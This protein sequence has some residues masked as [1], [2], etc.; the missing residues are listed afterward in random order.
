MKLNNK[1]NQGFTLLELILTIILVSLIFLTA[2]RIMNQLMHVR[3]SP[4]MAYGNQTVR[5]LIIDTIQND[6][7]LH[8]LTFSTPANP[9]PP[10]QNGGNAQQCA[11]LAAPCVIFNFQSFGR[12]ARLIFNDRFLFYRSFDNIE[13][14]WEFVAARSSTDA[15]Y[16]RA[17]VANVNAG[18]CNL[19]LAYHCFQRY[20][21]P[22]VAGQPPGSNEYALLQIRIPIFNYPFNPAN[23]IDN[24]NINDDIVLTYF[25]RFRQSP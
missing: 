21:T 24:N 9:F 14:T 11:P 15:R 23:S 25:G 16:N 20:Q 17:N 5:S 8:G 4:S 3:N 18:H 22:P 13:T 19:T 1:N 2:Q 12:P 6:W 10:P 7:L